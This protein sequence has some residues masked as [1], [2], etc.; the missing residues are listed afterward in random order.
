MDEFGEIT[1]CHTG[2]IQIETTG[3]IYSQYTGYIVTGCHTGDILTGITNYY[4]TGGSFYKNS[5]FYSFNLSSDALNYSTGNRDINISK[6]YSF[7]GI[8]PVYIQSNYGVNQIKHPLTL[9]NLDSYASSFDSFSGV[10]YY[11][12]NFLNYK[13]NPLVFLSHPSATIQS[14]SWNDTDGDKRISLYQQNKI[15]G[16]L[17]DT[18]SLLNV[19]FSGIIFDNQKTFEESLVNLNLNMIGGL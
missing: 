12:Y 9:C 16:S 11:F 6:N 17:K 4:A 5:D 15:D 13:N 2:E 14:A 1:G 3:W 19:N 8:Y 10:F 7:S 18:V